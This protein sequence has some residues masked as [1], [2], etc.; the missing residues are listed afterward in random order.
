ML[1]YETNPAEMERE[2]LQILHALILRW[3]REIVEFKEAKGQFNTDKL[4]Q[5]FSAISNEANLKNQQF[6]WMIFGVRESDR[7]IVGTHYKDTL[8]LEK[9]KHEIALNTTDGITFIDIYEVYPVVDGEKR[10]VVMF[11]IP[12]A[13][14]AM[15]TGWKNRYYGRNG[16]SLAPL[17]QYEIDVIRGQQ[18]KDWSK[19]LIPNSSISNLL[20]DAIKMA[21]EKYKGKQKRAHISEEVDAMTDE[22]F[23]T[24][25]RL[26]DGGLLTHAALVLLGNPD[27]KHLM[28]RPPTVMWRLFGG[29]GDNRDYEIFELPF[30]TIGDRIYEKLRNLTYRYMPN[31]RTL[32]P[33]ETMQYDQS[34]IYELINNCMAHQE[35]SMGPR[36]YVD[37]YEDKIKLTN[38][39]AFIPGD[40]RAVLDP[41]YAPPF[42]RNQLLA[43][44]MANFGMIDTATMGIRKV[45][46][47]L[48][49]KFF[50]M[51]DYETEHGQVK[52]TV[53]GKVLDINY[54]HLLFDNPDF[55]LNMV[56]LLDA[57]QKG[58]K[59]TAEESRKL[60]KMGLIEGKMPNLFI[61][62]GVA[63]MLDEKERYIKNKAFDDQYYKDLI[64]EYIKKFGSA[65]K[66]NIRELLTDKL[67]DV[68]DEKQKTYKIGNLLSALRREGKIET[69][70]ANTQKAHW[71]LSS[72]N[73][74]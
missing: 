61:S 68:L 31:Q 45:F 52:V 34:M 64:L 17:T 58:L 39:G 71:I 6:G 28:E 40:I 23:L 18:N 69:D 11:K 41:S 38:P 20:P 2:L 72:K 15:P 62:S 10:R 70:S 35:Y 8:S 1:T 4:G 49:R 29:A 24:K 7:H 21:R 32:F 66:K 33:I 25:L 9:L 30:I 3:E 14:T 54:T 60:R 43:E 59:I 73:N 67:P 65:N 12:A 74:N 22:A 26:V 53:Y 37:E 57:V 27:D 36:I 48:R 13:I 50:P 19:K 5:Y 16:E 56:F 42:Y 46:E 55:D 44:T 63:K 47:I 51:P